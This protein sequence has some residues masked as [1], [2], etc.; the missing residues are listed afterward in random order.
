MKWIATLALACGCAASYGNFERGV[1]APPKDSVAIAGATGNSFYLSSG[2]PADS[3]NYALTVT[4]LV[5]STTS[6]PVSVT[7]ASAILPT[8]I[9]QPVSVAVGTSGVVFAALD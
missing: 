6:S 8:F 1:A 2:T 5:G 4:N 7:I 3:G 9:Q